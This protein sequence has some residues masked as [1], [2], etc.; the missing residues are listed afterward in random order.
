MLLNIQEIYVCSLSVLDDIVNV[1]T[2]ND[3]LVNY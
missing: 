1:C 2:Y 3:V